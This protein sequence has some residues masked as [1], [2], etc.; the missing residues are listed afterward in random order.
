MRLRP[1]WLD[2]PIVWSVLC[3]GGA[4]AAAMLAVSGARLAVSFWRAAPDFDEWSCI[5][6][7]RA[8]SEGAGTLR[9]FFAPHYEHRIPLTRLLFLVDLEYFRGR[10]AFAH[11]VN[12]LSYAGLGALIG[13]VAS[14]DIRPCAERALVVAMAVAFALAPVQLFNLIYPFQLQMSLVCLCALAAFFFTARLATATTSRE[15]GVHTALAASAVLLAPYTSAN[16]VIA[17]IMTLALALAL[18]IGW[19]ARLIITAATALGLGGFFHGFQIHPDSIPQTHAWPDT[20]AALASLMGFMCALLGSIGQHRGVGT[21]LHLGIAGLTVWAALAF[22][23]VVL[24]YRG[25]V[26]ATLI[27]LTALAGF[28]VATALMIA[29]ARGM[30][31]MPQALF[32]RYGT[33]SAVFFASL[34]GAVFHLAG[35]MTGWQRPLKLIVIAAGAWL[36]LNA[37]RRPLEHPVLAGRLAHVDAAIVDLRAGRYDTEPVHKYLLDPGNLRPLVELL[38]ARRLAFFAE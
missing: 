15:R 11:G 17:S 26:N 37:Y 20:S 32:T 2:S 34:I 8:W 33:F 9:D 12:L 35:Q 27:A 19:R 3:A 18:P 21:A 7:Y 24:W 5:Q 30:N 16:G 36:L 13:V 1:K 31:G 28:A 29:F 6:L 10:M 23:T 22:W 38:R 25:A 4:I 14:R